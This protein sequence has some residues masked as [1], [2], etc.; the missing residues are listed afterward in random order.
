MGKTRSGDKTRISSAGTAT[1]DGFIRDAKF[2][3][4]LRRSERERHL[5]TVRNLLVGSASAL[6]LSCGAHQLKF[7]WNASIDTNDLAGY[8]LSYGSESRNYTNSVTII[9]LSTTNATVS[10]LQEGVTFYFSIAPLDKQGQVGPYCPDITWMFNP[11]PPTELK[12]DAAY[13]NRKNQSW[14]D[15]DI[16]KIRTGLAVAPRL[17]YFW[18]DLK[19][20]EFTRANPRMLRLEL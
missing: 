20:E 1:F 7:A 17:D 4:G 11:E 12:A 14:K 2:R 8:R 3:V 10:G 13:M 5:R 9:G 16:P 6:A 18:V 15:L 19:D